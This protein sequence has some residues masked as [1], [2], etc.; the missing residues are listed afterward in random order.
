MNR[1]HPPKFFLSLLIP[2]AGLFVSPLWALLAAQPQG[3]PQAATQ[4]MARFCVLYDFGLN[5]GDP[6]LQGGP[7]ALVDGGDGYFYSTSEQGGAHG[8]GTIFK[9]SPVDGKPPI[10]MHSF[11]TADGFGPRGGLMLGS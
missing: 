4:P 8:A 9:I 1:I 2:I 3:T 6:I 10:V 5:P 11:D 7:A